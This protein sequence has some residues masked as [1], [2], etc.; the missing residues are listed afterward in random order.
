MDPRIK[1]IFDK[2]DHKSQA[3]HLALVL[4]DI[5][6]AIMLV[7]YYKIDVFLF[8]KDLILDDRL[9][10]YIV[11]DGVVQTNEELAEVFESVAHF[12]EE[13]QRRLSYGRTD[14]KI[15]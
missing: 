13:V 14:K 1:E 9:K 10:D 5:M 11:M 6:E 8:I 12:V 15:D 4:R 2:C 3:T 7:C